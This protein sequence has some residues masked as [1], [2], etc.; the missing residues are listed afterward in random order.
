MERLR[1]WFKNAR[2][3]IPYMHTKEFNE[4]ERERERESRR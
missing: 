4:R 3:R 2:R 1:Q